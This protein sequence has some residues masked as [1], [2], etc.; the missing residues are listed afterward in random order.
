MTIQVE[1]CNSRGFVDFASAGRHRGLSSI[2]IKH[3]LFHQSNLGRDVVLQNTHIV[4][5]KS[6]HDV[7]R[8]STF[9]ALLR[10]GS[11]VVDWYRDATS[12]PNGHLLIDLSPR[13]DDRL[14]YCTNTGSIPWKFYVSNW[15]K[16]PKILAGEH[17]KCLNSPS[18][19][20]I[21]HKCKSLS[22]QSWPKEVIKF[23]CEKIVNILKENLQ[24]IKRQHV[25]KFQ[26]EV[27][28]LSSKRITW[29]QRRDVLASDSGLHLI[30]VITPLV[31]NLLSWHSAVCSWSCFLIQQEVE[32]PAS[33]KAGTTKVSTFKKSHVPK[34]FV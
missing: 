26:N 16:Q 17:S 33:F 2:Y 30:K 32:Y 29:K 18:V 8:V 24:S 10:L 3:N 14:R 6:L 15:L 22:L 20:I 21:F 27:R 7:L 12:V 28:W 4:L 31:T 34:W 23:L 19:S 9:R 13:T 1:I 11:E 5:F 25:A